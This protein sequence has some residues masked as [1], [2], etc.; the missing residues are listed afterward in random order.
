MAMRQVDV[1]LSV[2]TLVAVGMGVAAYRAWNPGPQPQ[3][4]PGVSEPVSGTQPAESPVPGAVV[5]ASVRRLPM[6]YGATVGKTWCRD[7][8]LY[9]DTPN[10]P[11][12][13]YANG[14]Y[15]KCQI[16]AEPARPQNSEASEQTP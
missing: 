2:L 12:P 7:G 16:Q 13:V 15:S 8:L 1:V 3:I 9:W 6:V 11:G 14:R 10:G 4:S 5:P